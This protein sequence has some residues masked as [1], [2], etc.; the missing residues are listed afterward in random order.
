MI[1]IFIL[2]LALCLYLPNLA[3]AAKG[4]RWTDTTDARPGKRIK[5]KTIEAD[6]QAPV[7]SVPEQIFS[8]A[9][10]ASGATVTFTTNTKDNVD[11]PLKASCT[12]VS[13]ALFELGNTLVNCEATDTAGNTSTTSFTVSVIDSTA[14]LISLPANI[15]IDSA[16][17]TAV[18]V[19]YSTSASDWVDGAITPNCTPASGTLFTLGE[20]TVQCVATD[21]AGNTAQSTFLITV[22]PLNVDNTAPQI[23]VPQ[24]LVV[25]AQGSTGANVSY[26]VSA[27][28]DTNGFVNVNCAPLSGTVFSLGTSTVNCEASDTAGNIATASFSVKVLDSQPPMLVVPSNI[29]ADSVDGKALVINFDVSANDVVDGSIAHSCAPSSGASFNVGETSVVCEASDS[30]GNAVWSSFLVTVIDA[31]PEPAPQQ[32]FSINIDWQIPTARADGTPL[33]LE[34]LAE[35]AIVYDNDPS[36]SDIKTLHV[37]SLNASGQPVSQFKILDLP[38]D[39]YYFAISAIDTEGMASDFSELVIVNLQ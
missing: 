23:S 35:Y 7:I 29:V 27:N 38:A 22:N 37:P 39:T 15:E 12:P 13:G 30:S 14:P 20:T 34:E 5:N 4:G 36:L 19:D 32:Y 2:L 18:P 33:A 31:T 11:G 10:S 24:N 1:R 6:T 21:A 26:S 16:N 8:E 25:E 17:G 28:D 3:L 9:L